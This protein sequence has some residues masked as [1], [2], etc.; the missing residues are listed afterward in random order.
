[1]IK[2][3]AEPIPNIKIF[4]KFLCFPCMSKIIFLGLADD[5]L[6]ARF[7]TFNTMSVT[8]S[9]TPL[10]EENSWRTPSIW[11]AETAAPWIEDNKILLNELP[12]VCPNPFSK[13]SATTFAIVLSS[14]LLISN[15]FGLIKAFQF[16][17]IIFDVVCLTLSFFLVV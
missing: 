4:L 6:I 14:L 10:I 3:I 15:L 8:S 2:Q 17:S 11:I 1:M 16:L 5:D 7:F 12:F 9:L 13:G